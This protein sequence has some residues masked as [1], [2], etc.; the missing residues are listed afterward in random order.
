MSMVRGHRAFSPSLPLSPP[1]G[2]RP[3]PTGKHSSPARMERDENSGIY[4]KQ[5]WQGILKEARKQFGVLMISE[6]SSCPFFPLSSR[7]QSYDGSSS[8]L[9]VPSSCFPDGS[10]P[11]FPGSKTS[12]GLPPHVYLLSQAQQAVD[13][14][15]CPP[16]LFLHCRPKHPMPTHTL[17]TE[18]HTALLCPALQTFAHAFRSMWNVLHLLSLFQDHFSS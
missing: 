9:S 17:F 7:Q 3:H 16:L 12:Y 13:V 11:S 14:P 1:S 18:P 15:T 5:N 10:D 2:L 4:G 8:L 6:R